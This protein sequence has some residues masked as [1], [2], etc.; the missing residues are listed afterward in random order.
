LS[1]TDHGADDARSSALGRDGVNEAPIDFDLIEFEIAQ[2]IEARV[3]GPEIIP[4]NAH[5][6]I[7]QCSV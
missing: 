7:S 5:T 1:K 6:G 3:T 4:G 2:V